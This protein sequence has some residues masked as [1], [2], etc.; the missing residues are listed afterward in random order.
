MPISQAF[1]CPANESPLLS[2]LFDGLLAMSQRSMLGVC[3]GHQTRLPRA[4]DGPWYMQR[5][6]SVS[7]CI[8]SSLQNARISTTRNFSYTVSCC[9]AAPSSAVTRPPHLM[10]R[11]RSLIEIRQACLGHDGARSRARATPDT[12]DRLHQQPGT[13]VSHTLPNTHAPSPTA[14]PRRN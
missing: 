8:A 6:S 1:C 14:R 2:V 11:P 7:H 3:A 9:Q 12:R 4:G 10:N 13:P 5:P